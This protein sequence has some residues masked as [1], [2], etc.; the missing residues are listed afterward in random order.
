VANPPR[1]CDCVTELPAAIAPTM[2]VG[3]R[4][5][6]GA[7]KDDR[8]DANTRR[9]RPQVTGPLGCRLESATEGFDC[10]IISFL[11]NGWVE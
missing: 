8:L 7:G 3:D 9:A 4:T 1:F 6:D 2:Y 5:M 10:S 11:I